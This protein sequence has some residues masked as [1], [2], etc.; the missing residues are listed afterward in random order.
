MP[1]T[2]AVPGLARVNANIGSRDPRN[3]QLRG[4]PKGRGRLRF[5]FAGELVKQRAGGGE[6]KVLRALHLKMVAQE[7]AEI[8]FFPFGQ[9]ANRPDLASRGGTDQRPGVRGINSF[10][11]CH[12][13][14]RSCV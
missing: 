13:F 10:G 12:T 4:Y 2:R 1:L 14:C 11:G 8:D 7:A 5:A 6:G 9:A 3:H